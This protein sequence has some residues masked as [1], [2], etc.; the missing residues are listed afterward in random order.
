[1]DCT[2]AIHRVPFG[3]CRTSVTFNAHQAPRPVLL[4]QDYRGCDRFLYVLK[5]NTRMKE[6]LGKLVTRIYFN[7]LLVPHVPPSISHVYEQTLKQ[8]VALVQSVK[9]DI[10]Q[11]NAAQKKIDEAHRQLQAFSHEAR[12]LFANPVWRKNLTKWVEE[13]WKVGEEQELP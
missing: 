10:A 5:L 7:D 1:M 3:V 9:R 8:T 13:A 11:R 4:I 2:G 6:P 12:M